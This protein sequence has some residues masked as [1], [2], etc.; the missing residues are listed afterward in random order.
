[1][2]TAADTVP[3]GVVVVYSDLACPWAHVAVTRLHATRRRLGLDGRVA[4]DHRAFPLELVNRRP[5]PKRVLDSEVPVL[6]ALQ[7]DAGWHSWNAP[8]SEYPVTT[9]PAM[10]AVQA[11]AAQGWA[12]SE[13]LDLALRCAFFADS[14]CISVLPV[15]LAVA[16]ACDGVDADLLA[17]ELESGRGHAAVMAQWRDIERWGVQGSPHVFAQGGCDSFNPG[18]TTEAIDIEGEH[19]LRVTADDPTAYEQILQTAATP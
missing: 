16:G 6:A 5:T 1:M 10:A 18:I 15:I 12:A 4:F 19:F 11:A 7:P 8:D 14:R 3:P 2:S 17:T 13:A 9:L